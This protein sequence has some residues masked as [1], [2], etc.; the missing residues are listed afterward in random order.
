[1]ESRNGGIGSGGSA[2]IGR[3]RFS[4]EQRR[5]CRITGVVEV[6]S[7]DE[8]NILM[9]TV[10]GMLAIKG[11]NLHVGR[12]NLEKGEADV[13]GTVDSLVYSDKN[14]LAKK[15]EGLLTRLFG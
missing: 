11:S 8:N 6:Q 12:L 15:G 9:E 13:D 14:T 4:M 7:F 1:M 10:D 2:G 5:E 3:H